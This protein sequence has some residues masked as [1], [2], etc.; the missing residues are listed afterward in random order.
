MQRLLATLSF[1]I[2]LLCPVT[3]PVAAQHATVAQQDNQTQTVY[4]T[5]SGKKYHLEWM[6]LPR[7]K[8]DCN[9]SEG[10]EGEG[11]HGVQGVSPAGVNDGMGEWMEI[12]SAD[13]ASPLNAYGLPHS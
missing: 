7:G 1:C 11:V 6:P 9:Q 13:K 5:R 12:R 8:Q 2:S 10:C 3:L 4:I